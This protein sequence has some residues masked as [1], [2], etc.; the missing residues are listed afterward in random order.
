[1]HG[2]RGSESAQKSQILDR[3]FGQALDLSTNL[4]LGRKL[5]TP[6][7]PFVGIAALHSPDQ[8]YDLLQGQVEFRLPVSPGM[9]HRL[10]DLEQLLEVMRLTFICL[11]K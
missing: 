1:M 7:P 11:Q 9:P 5:R 8:N 2:P 10:Q 4:G 3:C 6:P